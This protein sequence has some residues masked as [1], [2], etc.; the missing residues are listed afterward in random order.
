MFNIMLTK[1]IFIGVV[2]AVV[3]QRIFEV[4]FSKRNAAQILEKGGQKHGDNLLPFVKLMQIL[5]WICMVAEVWLLDRP[6]IPWLAAVALVGVGIGQLLRFYSMRALEWRWTLPI[7]TVPDMPRVTHGIYQYLRHP[8]WLGVGI[9]IAALPLLHSAYLTALLFSALNAV[10][11]FK[12][13]QLEEEV[14]QWALPSEKE[15]VIR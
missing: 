2:L 3:I 11:M 4:R 12:R 9:E 8:N 6:F 14:F 5:W 10:V 7:M 1:W 13:I 15:A